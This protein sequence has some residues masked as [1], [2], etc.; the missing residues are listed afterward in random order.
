MRITWIEV[1]TKA[2]PQPARNHRNVQRESEEAYHEPLGQLC[3]VRCEGAL[4]SLYIVANSRCLIVV[5]RSLPDLQG[6]LAHS[7]LL[8][9]QFKRKLE[10]WDF[11][12]RD[13]VTVTHNLTLRTQ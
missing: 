12:K 5:S 11:R 8:I 6:H 1:M 9:S 3:K 7:Q 2:E 13:R 4:S 10:T